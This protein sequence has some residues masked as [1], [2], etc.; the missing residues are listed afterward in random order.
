MPKIILTPQRSKDLHHS[1]HSLLQDIFVSFAQS[2]N[3]SVRTIRDYVINDLSHSRVEKAVDQYREEA[4]VDLSEISKKHKQ[5][6]RSYDRL[7]QL[8]RDRI[9]FLE[10]KIKF[11]SFLPW[12]WGKE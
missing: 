4:L 10:F 8:L 3:C 1:V 11:L 9:S 6:L 2:Y 5:D 12:N 7:N